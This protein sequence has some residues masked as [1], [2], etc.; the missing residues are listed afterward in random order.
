LH[1]EC[2]NR[3]G[4][5]SIVRLPRVP[6]LEKPAAIDAAGVAA[7]GCWEPRCGEIYTVV[8]PQNTCY[9]ARLEK[10]TAEGGIL[11][12]FERFSLSPESDLRVEVFQALPEKERFEL[13]LQKLTELGVDRIAPYTSVRSTSLAERD[14]GQKKSH[15]WPD[16]IRRAA[17][18]CRRAMLPELLPVL[19]WDAAL[20]AAGHADLRLMLFEGD[21]SWTLGEALAGVNSNRVAI[22]V[23]PEGGFTPE[24]VAAARE[25]GFLPV[26]LGAR[27]LRTE[28]A[29]IVAAG[30]IQ[31]ALGDLG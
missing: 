29:A 1:P 2:V 18:Q 15:R 24:E 22:L 31:F 11:V 13:I 17:R 16:V 14:A 4:K 28:T 6:E 23:G 10:F 30:V 8:D 9:R 21:A 7:L 20:Y 26:S 12:P 25:L 3:G 5:K 27:M 19:D